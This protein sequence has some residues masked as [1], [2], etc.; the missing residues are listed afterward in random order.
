MYRLLIDDPIIQPSTLLLRLKSLLLPLSSRNTE[1][2]CC[3]N[4]GNYDSHVKPLENLMD[5]DS[6]ICLYFSSSIVSDCHPPF[7]LVH[8]DHPLLSRSQSH[9]LSRMLKFGIPLCCSYNSFT[10]FDCSLTPNI[11]K[12]R[13]RNAL[14]KTS[15]VLFFRH[16]SRSYL[17]SEI[18]ALTFLGHLKTVFY[19]I[20][21][22]RSTSLENVFLPLVSGGLFIITPKPICPSSLSAI[23]HIYFYISRYSVRDQLV[24][25]YFLSIHSQSYLDSFRI[26]D[27]VSS[28]STHLIRKKAP[29]P[30][31]YLS[32]TLARLV[33]CL[34]SFLSQF[35]NF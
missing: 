27:L 9:R 21:I 23:E 34:L 18:V 25:S 1:L 10:Y 4:I 2:I 17:L 31:L 35:R 24:A 20:K 19:F 5:C 7:I 14:N 28:S 12:I 3:V 13:A 29:T 15:D 8:V 26:V 6:D 11:T 16:Y 32:E 33:D 22:F 30:L